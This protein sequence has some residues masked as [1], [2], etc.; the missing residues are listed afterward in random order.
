MKKLLFLF[1]FILFACSGSSDETSYTLTL[2]NSYNELVFTQV[3]LPE[4]NFTA[5][6]SDSQTF[7]LNN[8]M[9]SMSNVKVDINFECMSR[10][11]SSVLLVN[12]Y[13][14][15]TTIIETNNINKTSLGCT[16]QYTVTY[17]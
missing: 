8:G 14:G 11:S 1:A 2:K 15:Q 5:N 10:T 3:A 12:F 6:S 13:E 17:E 9:S 7:N 16:P 4:Y